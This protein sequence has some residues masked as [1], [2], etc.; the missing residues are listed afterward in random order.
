MISGS[1]SIDLY[2]LKYYRS[3]SELNQQN[4]TVV[5]FKPSSATGAVAGALIG[6]C[7]HLKFVKST[8][9]SIILV[10]NNNGYLSNCLKTSAPLIVVTAAYSLTLFTMLVGRMAI[11]LALLGWRVKPDPGD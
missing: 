11:G 2:Y 9:S 1:D 8:R 5:S 3:E 7:F 4:R 10:V 6:N